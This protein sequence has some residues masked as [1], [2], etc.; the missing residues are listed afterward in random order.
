MI[1]LLKLN[2]N[3]MK[4]NITMLLLAISTSFFGQSKAF[5]NI[6]QVRE[7]SKK[8]ATQFLNKDMENLFNDLKP[9]WVISDSQI[10]T[11]KIRTQGF[12]PMIRN[13]YGDSVDVVKI[14]ETNLENALLQETYLVRYLRSALRIKLLYYNN[15]QGWFL[16]SF[17]WDDQI[18]EE[19]D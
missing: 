16:N 14:K 11:L 19:I 8:V 1:N 9:Y 3:I 6:N 7:N 15:N 13:S 4:N 10:D 2:L 12:V 17:E 5:E 18:S